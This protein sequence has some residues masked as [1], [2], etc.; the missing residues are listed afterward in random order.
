MEAQITGH[1]RAD[2]FCDVYGTSESGVTAIEATKGRNELRFSCGRKG[3]RGDLL[4][5]RTKRRGESQ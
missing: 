4:K 5:L 2:V 1:A 3:S